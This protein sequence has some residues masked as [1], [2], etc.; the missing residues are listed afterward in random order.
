MRERFFIISIFSVLFFC[1]CKERPAKAAERV[2]RVRIEAPKFVA[3]SA[4]RY[5]EEQLAFGYRIPNT[6]AHRKTAIFLAAIHS[7]SLSLEMPLKGL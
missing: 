1:G 6:E 2:E 4:Y 3:D 7:S 5:T